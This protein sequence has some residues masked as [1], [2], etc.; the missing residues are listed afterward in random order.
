M[1]TVAWL[2]SCRAHTVL[3]LFEEAVHSYRLPS[4][5]RGDRGVEN[6]EV[7]DYTIAQQGGGRA[8][9]I[10]GRSVHNQ[11]IERLW[12]DVFSGCTVLYYQLFQHLEAIGLLHVDDEVELFSLHYIFLPRINRSLCQFIGTWNN[13]PLA[14]ASNLSPIQLWMS[15]EH[16]DDH[17]DEVCPVLS[18]Q[19]FPIV[20]HNSGQASSFNVKK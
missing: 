7:A 8:S 16:P 11:R 2:C 3:E 13:H 15:E 20:V 10:C 14:T 9:F 18:M 6:V 1:A 17:H 12:R 4:R 5:V 19:E